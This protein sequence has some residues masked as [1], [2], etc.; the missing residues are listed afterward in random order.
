[1]QAWGSNGRN[2]IVPTAGVFEVKSAT[3]VPGVLGAAEVAAGGYFTCARTKGG[4]KVFCWGDNSGG[5][6]GTSADAGANT[7][8]PKEVPGIDGAERLAAG[9]TAFV[10]AIVNGAVLCWGNNDKGQLGRGSVGG[11]FPMPAKLQL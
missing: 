1:V 6:M 3:Q 9:R 2:A 5:Q 11:T 4:G 10:C 7:N 8:P